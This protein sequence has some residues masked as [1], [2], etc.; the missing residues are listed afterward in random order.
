MSG[1][2]HRKRAY[3]GYLTSGK[4]QLASDQEIPGS[5]QPYHPGLLGA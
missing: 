4:N 5:P 3:S 2:P 1:T